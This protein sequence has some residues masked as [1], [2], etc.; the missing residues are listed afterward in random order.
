MARPTGA[1]PGPNQYSM[2]RETL[3]AGLLGAAVVA[4]WFLALDIFRGRILFTP[5]ALGSAIF[6]G[7]R[8]ES[9][10]EISALT[11]IGYTVL[12][13]LAFIAAALIAVRVF[14]AGESEPKAMM[15]LPVIFVTLEVFV[16]GLLAILASWL[17]DALSLWSVALGTLFGAAAMGLFLW[18]QHPATVEGM[19]VEVEEVQ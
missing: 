16:I 17:L 4:I 5:A 6:L 9:Q 14:R 8:G 13:V 19:R 10:V 2:T 12:H 1:Y 15:G 7:A 11:V 18:R 3:L